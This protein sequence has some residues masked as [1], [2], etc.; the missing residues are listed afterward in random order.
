MIRVRLIEEYQNWYW[1]SA[2][3]ITI[4]K[5]D[6]VG[7]EVDENNEMVRLALNQGFLEMVSD[8]EYEKQMALLNKPVVKEETTILKQPEEVSKIMNTGMTTQN[9]MREVVSPANT[10][11]MNKIK[12]ELKD[13]TGN[14]DT[15]DK[16]NK[17]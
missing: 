11:S 10:E 15:S 8:E 3:G 5:E 12:E 9:T 17:F 1:N 6:R 4:K 16:E 2:T 14:T 7:V 13:A